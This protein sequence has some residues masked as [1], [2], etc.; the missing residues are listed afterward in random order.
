VN[1]MGELTERHLAILSGIDEHS[2]RKGY[3][4]T[5]RELTEMVGLKSVSTLYGHLERLQAQG[6]VVWDPSKP[7]TLTRVKTY[8]AAE[9]DE[10]R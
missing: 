6:Y 5:M 8:I 10:S 9:S 7:R 3:P 2:A 1:G 4:P